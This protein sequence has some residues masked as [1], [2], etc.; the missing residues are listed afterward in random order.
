MLGHQLHAGCC[1]LAW[2][3][4]IN[5]DTQRALFTL[6]VSSGCP[7]KTRQTPPKPP[8]KKFF[9]GLIGCGCLDMFTFRCAGKTKWNREG[10]E[11]L[12]GKVHGT[13]N[14]ILPGRLCLR[15]MRLCTAVTG[16]L[17]DLSPTCLPGPFWLQHSS[18]ASVSVCCPG[19]NF[20]RAK[21]INKYSKQKITV[22]IITVIKT[23]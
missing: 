16:L 12:R 9:I 14:H 23:S 8:A 2:H 22:I 17:L 20:Q 18:D 15:E 21:L 10:A 6:M 4:D 1:Y 11:T 13:S 7:A 5:P 19:G 3:C